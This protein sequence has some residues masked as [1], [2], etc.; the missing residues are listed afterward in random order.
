MP[1]KY[2]L[3]HDEFKSI[4][5]GTVANQPVVTLSMVGLYFDKSC[6]VTY[7]AQ[8]VVDVASHKTKTKFPSNGD[9]ATTSV[10]W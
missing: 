3:A 6:S 2:M 5:P 10:N 1:V 7:Y 9:N 8:A 4:C